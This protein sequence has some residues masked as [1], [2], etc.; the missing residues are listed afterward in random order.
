[1]RHQTPQN[2]SPVQFEQRGAQRQRAPHLPLRRYADGFYWLLAAL[3]LVLTSAMPALAAP[4]PSAT[5]TQCPIGNLLAGRSP[6]QGTYGV[7]RSRQLT[8]GRRLSA[9]A[10][11]ELRE[12]G[13]ISRSGKVIWDLGRLTTLRDFY[14]Q[15]D[16]NDTY[17]LEGSADLKGFSP[18]WEAQPVKS[19]GLQE[20]NLRLE[21]QSQPVRYLRLSARGG[22][23]RFSV[24]EL[25]VFCQKIATWPPPMRRVRGHSLSTS[26]IRKHFIGRAK[27]GVALFA[28]LLFFSAQFSPRRKKAQQD[29][30]SDDEN[31]EGVKRLPWLSALIQGLPPQVQLQLKALSSGDWSIFTLPTLIAASLFGLYLAQLRLNDALDFL[32]D[33]GRFTTSEGSLLGALSSA[34]EWSG[35]HWAAINGLTLLGY[36]I[37]AAGV[38]IWLSQREQLNARALR[39]LGSGGVL[40]VTLTQSADLLGR[41][42]HWWPQG[43]EAL[44]VIPALFL[45]LL[46]SERR[47][48]IGEGG[49]A[50]WYIFGLCGALLW[51]SLGSFH[52]H[53]MTHYWDSFHYYMG[54]KYFPENRYHLLYHCAI[55]AEWDDGYKDEL[56]T[57]PLRDLRDNRLGH[58]R[59]ALD[60][61]HPSTRACRQNFSKE[62]WAAF[63]QDLRFFR[64]RMADDKWWAKMFKDHGYNAT[65]VWNMVGHFLSNWG[66]RE[67]LPQGEAYLRKNPNRASSLV[68]SATRK[69]FLREELP[70]FDKH[71]RAL[72][73]IDFGLYIFLFSM[74]FFAFGARSGAAAVAVMALAY[75]HSYDWTGGSFG[76]VPWLFMMVSGLCLL[77]RGK[78]LLGGFTLAWSM[79]LRI[80]PGALFIGAA[81][82][83]IDRW[84]RWL[85]VERPKEQREREHGGLV[86]ESWRWFLSERQL[87]RFTFGALLA[88]ATLIPLS[89]P[90]ATGVAPEDSAVSAWSA[91]MQNSLK[92][93]ATPL[94]NHMG[95]PTLLSYHPRYI[96]RKT[97]QAEEKADGSYQDP[98]A[99]WKKMRKQLKVDRRWIF[100]SVLLALF[101]ALTVLSRRLPLWAITA[102]SAVCVASIFELTCY[103]YSFLIILA[104]LAASRGRELLLFFALAVATQVTQ[105]RVGWI[106][107]EYF[108]VTV[109]VLVPLTL[110]IASRLWGKQSALER[111]AI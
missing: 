83:I 29:D 73:L 4:A 33:R 51:L 45:F 58:A 44:F 21:G 99:L 7:T 105:I 81:L 26:D 100:I 27:I 75:P 9:G 90:S 110:L 42:A 22:D 57:R 98:F 14:I 10:Y 80:F 94:T 104:P 79:L 38:G 30:E 97:R 39:L 47:P 102:M 20:R 23:G 54:S 3:A 86:K 17:L 111:E 55:V 67:H 37:A 89:F 35:S 59:E 78:P 60:E 61:N 82:A 103:Y 71:L 53:R 43:Y 76:R 88:V 41:S 107:E 50:H 66:W 63:R 46:W 6:I 68:Q 34:T 12:T 62:R 52:S 72:N 95:L 31:D 36:A 16:N 109:A 93:N 18:L 24:S 77:R 32:A 8:D 56:E 106:D 2:A 19:S 87:S 69:R 101:A 74:I 48:A 91:F 1:M 64:S 96:A 11:W 40:T 5:Q 28:L 85:R 49:R 92:H 84:V 25:Q 108:W 70:L 15:A 13:I 65:P